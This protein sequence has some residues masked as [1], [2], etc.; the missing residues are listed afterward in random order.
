MKK[1]Q[2]RPFAVVTGASNG[3]GF[4]LARE[5]AVRGYDLLLA[6]RGCALEK[7]AQRLRAFGT[8]VETLRTDL[9]TFN[10]VE[11]LVQKVEQSGRP[12]ALAAL[13]AG[14][15]LGGDFSETNLH[16]EL[17]LIQLNVVSTVHLAKH[18]AS[19]MREKGDGHLLFASTHAPYTPR[20]YE[21]VYGASKAFVIVRGIPRQGTR[22]YR[23]YGNHAAAGFL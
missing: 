18:L 7:S 3:I 6:A 11:A 22:R 5:L 16:D 20:P 13:N 15:S 10:G 8:E 4:E 23:R 1:K 14:V 9:A 17:K 19:S 12:V 21:A 2:A